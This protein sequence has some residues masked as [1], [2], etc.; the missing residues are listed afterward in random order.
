MSRSTRCQPA[1]NGRNHLPGSKKR[2]WILSGVVPIARGIGTGTVDL[3][4]WVERRR[5][6]EPKI[7]CQDHLLPDG[8]TCWSDPV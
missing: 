1:A 3:S 5:R 4:I 6:I 2:Q 8:V 7:G